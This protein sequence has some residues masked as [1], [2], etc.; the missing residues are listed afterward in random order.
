MV[1]YQQ[2]LANGDGNIP[3]KYFR[4]PAIIYNV[5]KAH[6]YKISK[7]KYLDSVEKYLEVK[8]TD[9]MIS[10]FANLSNK[11]GRKNE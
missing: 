6:G 8:L 1:L 11:G 4:A 5:I 2:Y 3:K 7:K 10:K 9:R